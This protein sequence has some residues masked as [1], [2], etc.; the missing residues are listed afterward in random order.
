MAILNLHRLDNPGRPLREVVLQDTAGRML[1]RQ[2][3]DGWESFWGRP[4]EPGLL[5]RWKTALVHA[6]LSSRGADTYG[7]LLAAAELVLGTE[8]MKD[9]GLPMYDDEAL[10]QLV[11][12]ET[13]SERSEQADNW[14]ECLQ[15]LLQSQIE[16]W[17]GGEKPTVGGV[18]DELVHRDGPPLDIKDAR[19]KLAAAG[20]GL[21]D[22]GKVCDGYALAIPAKGPVLAKI[23]RDTKWADGVWYSALKQE[24]TKQVVLRGSD[25]RFVV[26]IN[27]VACKCLLVDLDSYD[28]ASMGE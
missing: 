9:A 12:D 5:G 3:M 4:G 19:P 26:K 8:A 20:L 11:L 7:T 16:A 2:I 18:L 24:P 14:E 23:F 6:G 1:L 25:N 21:V 27:K 22:K 28:R 15:H 17:K 13:A 10:A